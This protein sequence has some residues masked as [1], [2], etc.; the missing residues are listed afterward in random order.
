[1]QAALDVKAQAKMI[2]S[3]VY[4]MNIVTSDNRDNRDFSKV[5]ISQPFQQLI[6]N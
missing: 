3:K 1:M 6:I 4:V 2:L 5:T